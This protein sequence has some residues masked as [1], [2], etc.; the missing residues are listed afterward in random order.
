MAPKLLFWTKCIAT[1][2]LIYKWA[3]GNDCMKKG[4]LWN[5]YDPIFYGSAVH[6]KC[7]LKRSCWI[8]YLM[9]PSK[10]DLIKQQDIQ[11]AVNSTNLFCTPGINLKSFSSWG[12]RSKLILHHICERSMGIQFHIWGKEVVFKFCIL[13]AAFLRFITPQFG[14]TFLAFSE[15][16]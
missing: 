12:F 4:L 6:M 14:F 10:T 9:P 1:S 8:T 2:W 7:I 13:I 16:C 5:H 15:F 3:T 11:R